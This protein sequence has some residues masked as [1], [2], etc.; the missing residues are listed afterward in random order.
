M[1]KHVFEIT[2]KI[3]NPE[4]RE[5]YDKKQSDLIKNIGKNLFDQ[6]CDSIETVTEIK[7]SIEQFI[8]NQNNNENQNND[9]EI[10]ISYAN[11]FGKEYSLFSLTYEKCK[12]I[13]DREREFY[14]FEYYE[15]FKNN[16]IE[17]Y[18]F[19]CP[20]YLGWELVVETNVAMYFYVI[21]LRKI[22]NKK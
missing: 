16:I 5:K 18:E 21:K 11:Y 22:T 17:P 14:P 19:K 7:Q 2:E 6:V 4:K 12:T 8:N 1:E 10:I 15:S 9:D 20:E 3:D 13:L